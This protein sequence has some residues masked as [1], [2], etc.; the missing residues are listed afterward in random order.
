MALA[1]IGVAWRARPLPVV[2]DG[3]P[4]SVW[5]AVVGNCRHEPEGLAPSWRPR[6]DDGRLDVRMVDANGPA[7]R[8]RAALAL[9]AG[10][11]PRSPVYAS[12]QPEQLQIAS[13]RPSLRLARDGET[14]DGN[15]SFSVRKRPRRLVVFA[16]TNG[17]GDPRKDRDHAREPLRDD[18]RRVVRT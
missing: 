3:R 6:L 9:M 13:D 7:S 14:F 15:G 4:R 11:L 17:A 18:A 1:I 8:L 12:W 2:I 16:P 5:T 10:R